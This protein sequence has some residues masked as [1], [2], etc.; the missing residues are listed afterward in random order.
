MLNGHELKAHPLQLGNELCARRVVAYGDVNSSD[1]VPKKEAEPVTVSAHL[2]VDEP[3]SRLFSIINRADD[4][5]FI[6][7]YHC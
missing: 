1:T 4:V 7:T 6:A 3:R 5:E 2:G